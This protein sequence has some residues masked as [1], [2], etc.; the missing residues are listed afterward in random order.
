MMLTKPRLVIALALVTAMTTATSIV[1]GRSVQGRQSSVS[2]NSERT[3]VGVWR[4]LVTPRNCQT[5]EPLAPAFPGLFTF[6]EGGTM[7]EYG[8]GPGSSPALR[9]PGHGVW[10]REHSWQDY[11]LAFT[12]YRYNAS[13]LFLGSQKVTAAL[14]LGAS[15]DD[16]TT[17]STI[18][19][20]DANDNVIATACGTA[21]GTRFE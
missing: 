16:F 17:N 13:G 3:I 6:N 12:Y 14:E 4:T 2:S 19:V 8:I 7:S 21:V 18:E 5:G 15:G 1:S 11:S 10:Q 9:S 20:L